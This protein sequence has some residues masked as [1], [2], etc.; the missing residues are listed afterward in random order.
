MH[1]TNA[2]GNMFPLKGLYENFLMHHDGV[3]LKLNGETFGSGRV[4]LTNR[5]LIH[6]RGLSNV[7]I[8]VQDLYNESFQQ[9]LIGPNSFRAH[10]DVNG[11]PQRV[12]LEFEKGVGSF[13]YIMISVLKRESRL[14]ES[15]WHLWTQTTHRQF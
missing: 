2:H 10:M 5:R 6:Q 11:N 8:D 15:R 3:V 14:K 9:N 13:L 1:S 7:E 4:F 12:L